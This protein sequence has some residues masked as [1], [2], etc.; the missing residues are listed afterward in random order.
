MTIADDAPSTSDRI[1]RKVEGDALPVVL[2]LLSEN[3]KLRATAADIASTKDREWRALIAKNYNSDVSMM[4]VTV[5]MLC[6]GIVVG[7]VVF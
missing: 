7:V 4:I 2:E 5:V 6:L 1:R 3:Q